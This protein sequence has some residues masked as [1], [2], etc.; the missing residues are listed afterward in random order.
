MNVLEEQYVVELS[1]SRV[2]R[3]LSLQQVVRSV[4]PHSIGHYLGMDVHDTNTI[5]SNAKLQPGMVV[6]IEPGLYFPYDAYF[7]K[8]QYVATHSLCICYVD[9]VVCCLLQT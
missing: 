6:T 8:E 5:P 7:V 1:A 4:F 9:V 3:A 2:Q